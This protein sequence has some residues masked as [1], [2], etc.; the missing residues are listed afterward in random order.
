MSN[1]KRIVHITTVDLTLRLMLINQL[2]YIMNHNYSVSAISSSGRFIDDVKNAGINHIAVPISRHIVSP[3]KDLISFF[4][5]IQVLRKEKFVIVHTHTPKASFI[6]QITAKLTGTPIIIRTLHGFYFHENTN[7]VVRRIFILLES[8][9]SNFSDLILSQNRED[10]DTAIQEG[11]CDKDRIEFLGNGIDIERFNP[12]TINRS[13]ISK[14]SGE[15]D[16]VKDKKVIGFVGRLVKEKGIYELIQA[17]KIVKQS[18]DDIQFLIIGPVDYDK[19][20]AVTPEIAKEQG[21]SD[22]FIFTGYQENMPLLYSLMDIFVLP[23]H[24]EGFPRS[25]ME[26]SA[27]KIP[28]VTMDIRGCRE[29]VD[30]GKNGL[31]VPLGDVQALAQAI[32]RLLKN[33]LE[34]KKMGEAGR[35]IAVERFDERMVFDKVIQSYQFLLMKKN[36]YNN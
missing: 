5:L 21:V 8:F 18:I 25:P 13:D 1:T 16:L 34:A 30:D 32:V 35:Q 27:M 23:S 3:L 36:L 17:A 4:R 2:K 24:R 22:Y 15:L 19:K 28:T 7:P 29:V 12:L 33:P 9:A 10:I 14:V 11:I 26:A 20:D 6:G 31:L